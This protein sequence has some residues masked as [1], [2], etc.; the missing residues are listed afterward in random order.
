MQNGFVCAISLNIAA[1]YHAF[2]L[3]SRFLCSE[4]GS[5]ARFEMS[6]PS[7]V[8][9]CGRPISYP[10]FGRLV[11]CSLYISVGIKASPG[12]LLGLGGATLIP[13]TL[14]RPEQIPRRHHEL[15][16]VVQ[17]LVCEFRLTWNKTPKVYWLITNS[18][19]NCNQ[20]ETVWERIYLAVKAKWN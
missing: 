12:N 6:S 10:A 20:K 8:I 1:I 13:F 7:T 16:F 19:I 9:W 4:H 3:N 14:H 11:L 15:Q 18:K 2:C 5:Y 17:H